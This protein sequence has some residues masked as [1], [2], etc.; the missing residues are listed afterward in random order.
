MITPWYPSEEDPV[1]GKFVRDQAEILAEEHN[2]A[3]LHGTGMTLKGYLKKGRTL[4]SVEK[5]VE[6]FRFSYP[7]IPRL[8]RIFYL[9]KVKRLFGELANKKKI[10][11]VHAHVTLPAGL[12]A[13]MINKKFNI[14]TVITEHA[15]YL[16]KEME[17]Y[18]KLPLLKFAWRNANAVIAVSNSLKREIKKAVNREIEVIPNVIDTSLFGSDEQFTKARN[19]IRIIFI[20]HMNTESKGVDL[21]LKAMQD[22]IKETGRNIE[23]HLYGGG[24]FLDKYKKMS[25]ELNIADYCIFHGFQSPEKVR[26]G[27]ARSDFFVLPSRAESFSIATAEAMA[28]GKPVVVTKCGGPEE[29][30]TGSSGYIIPPENE[31]EL[32]KAILLMMSEYQSFDP[33][34]ISSIIEHRF[35]R[36]VFQS[37]INTLYSSLSSDR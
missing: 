9:R 14:P 26:S 36:K 8:A 2:V 13:V 25:E 33:E 12:A 27:L 18:R 32:K 10:E 31:V 28:C 3:V 6:V 16:E 5:G 24:Y 17:H 19:E 35:G 7:E 1:S 22:I 11:V 37:N 21:L 30:V 20:G 4:K 34:E 15:S 29:Y 23:L